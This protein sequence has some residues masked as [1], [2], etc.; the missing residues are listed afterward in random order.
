MTIRLPLT[1]STTDTDIEIEIEAQDATR[2]EHVDSDAESD[3]EQ[4]STEMA[5]VKAR[6][7][8]DGIVT[9][10]VT[11]L[12][13][14]ASDT[15]YVVGVDPPYG[16]T[17]Y[18]SFLVPGAWT[19]EHAFKR[20]V[21]QNGYDAE[22]CH[23]MVA[24][25]AEVAV[26]VEDGTLVVPDPPEPRIDWGTVKHRVA[27]TATSLALFAPVLVFAVYGGMVGPNPG[28]GVFAGGALGLVFGLLGG[29][30][31]MGVFDGLLGWIDE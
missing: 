13:K 15:Q 16:D 8:A 29:M 22:N 4:V 11:T 9:G 31:S 26:D 12:R 23:R 17:I 10:S 30:V 7:E 21:E 5:E 24:D 27:L 25:D 2:S 28:E 6:T 18:R 14:G 20:W 1:M 19:D 3:A